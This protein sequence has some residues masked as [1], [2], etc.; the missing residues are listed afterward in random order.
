M[1]SQIRANKKLRLYIRNTQ[2]HIKELQLTQNST[3]RKVAYLLEE[4]IGL[5]I[6][7]YKVP[8]YSDGYK[9]AERRLNEIQKE[10]NALIEERKELQN[11]V[12]LINSYA[13]P[14]ID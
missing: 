2:Y 8:A 3:D 7:Q 13:A 9:K 1:K 4:S 14:S 10:I 12:T 11:H 5:A 6:L